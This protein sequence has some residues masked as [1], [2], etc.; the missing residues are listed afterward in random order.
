MWQPVLLK[1]YNCDKIRQEHP[2][3]CMPSAHVCPPPIEG[4][5]QSVAVVKRPARKDNPLAFSTKQEPVE[6]LEVFKFEESQQLQQA[7]DQGAT[8]INEQE[9]EHDRDSR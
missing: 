7:T 2:E 5:V 8:R 4:G 6:K 9:T 1:S 3:A